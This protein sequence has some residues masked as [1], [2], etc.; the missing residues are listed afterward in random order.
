MYGSLVVLKD[1]KPVAS[2]Y[3]GNQ[4]VIHRFDIMPVGERVTNNAAELVM[5]R[6][7]LKYV[8]QLIERHCKPLDILIVSDSEWALKLVTGAYKLGNKTAVEYHN[9]LTDIKWDKAHLE[10][11]GCTILFQ[12]V[13]NEWVKSVLGH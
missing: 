5:I 11:A 2:T 6:T 8:R 9:F 1:G 7:A 12:H 10:S 4:E 13:A 3:N